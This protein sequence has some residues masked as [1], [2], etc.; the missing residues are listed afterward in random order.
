MFKEIYIRIKDIVDEHLLAKEATQLPEKTTIESLE[1][2]DFKTWCPSIMMHLLFDHT[3]NGRFRSEVLKKLIEKEEPEFVFKSMES[4]CFYQLG[5]SIES[6]ELLMNTIK[7]VKFFMTHAQFIRGMEGNTIIYGEFQEKC[8]TQVDAFCKQI[9]E[10]L[11][12]L[13]VA[14][15]SENIG[16]AKAN[17]K[18]LTQ[19]KKELLEQYPEKML[20][21]VDLLQ[22]K[23]LDE[24]LEA[25]NLALTKATERVEVILRVAEATEELGRTEEKYD[26]IMNKNGSGQQLTLAFNNL[27]KAH[28]NKMDALLSKDEYEKK[29]TVAAP[30]NNLM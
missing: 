16:T 23:S 7:S 10:N 30:A 6:L 4:R 24:Y 18:Q 25:C 22:Q 15:T 8:K 20:K 14:M 5:I 11:E 13:N 19:V 9:Q 2:E 1:D 12:L 21:D 27:L 26:D 28:H 17:I 29:Y 3:Q